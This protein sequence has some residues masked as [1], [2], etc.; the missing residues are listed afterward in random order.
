MRFSILTPTKNRPG[1]LA[2]AVES[3]LAQTYDD[4]ELVIY[5]NGER[6]VPQ[7]F[8]A[9]ERIRCHTGPATCP[10]DAFGHALELATGDVLHPLA[11][12]DRLTPWALEHVAAELAAYEWLIGLTLVEDL[13]GNPERVLGGPVDLD[14]LAAG[15]YLGGA[16]YWRRTL[17][18]RLGGFD[19]TYDPAADYDLYTRFAHAAPAK[20]VDRILYRY[21]DHPKTDSRVRAAE[22][23]AQAERVRGR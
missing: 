14:R 4:W 5:D 23:L 3:V 15:F 9:D 20:F 13:E 8:L 11:D 7:W 19:V 2:R 6:P 21:T 16:I 22:Q 12:D 17:T 1:W 18:D 10:A